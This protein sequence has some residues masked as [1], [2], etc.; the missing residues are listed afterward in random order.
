M[1]AVSSRNEQIVDILLENGANPNLQNHEGQSSLIRAIDLQDKIIAIKLIKNGAN[2]NA[3][4][5]LGLT[6]LMHAAID[7]DIDVADALISNS[8]DIN[9][10]DNEGWSALMYAATSPMH[11]NLTMIDMLLDSKANVRLKT[12]KGETAL[13]LAAKA[14]NAS[15][16]LHLLE[17]VTRDDIEGEMGWRALRYADLEKAHDVERLLCTAGASYLWSRCEGFA[18]W[19]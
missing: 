2:A 18:A 1:H 8:A 10:Q 14:R 9:A 13:S 16:V 7:N 3:K 17:T 15:R 5:E 11:K 4:N 19:R 6:A 12:T